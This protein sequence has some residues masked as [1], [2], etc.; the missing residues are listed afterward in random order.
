MEKGKGRGKQVL[1]PWQ[2]SQSYLPTVGQ[3]AGAGAQ[4]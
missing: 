3:L 1:G 4:H 2:H